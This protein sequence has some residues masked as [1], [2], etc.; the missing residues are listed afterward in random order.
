MS[1]V[2]IYSFVVTYESLL[3]LASKLFSQIVSI[4]LG[5]PT[6][7]LDLLI[8]QLITF[9]GKPQKVLFMWF[10][11]KNIAFQPRARDSVLGFKLL[12]GII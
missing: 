6:M 7:N 9:G 12:L 2:K 1:K 3:F 4:K 11:S 5:K 10:L 8:W